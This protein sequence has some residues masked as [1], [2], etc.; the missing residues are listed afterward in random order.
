LE[1][2]KEIRE[3]LSAIKVILPSEKRGE[4]RENLSVIRR[5]LPRKV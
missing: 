4:I 2:R 3:N 1:K 5:N